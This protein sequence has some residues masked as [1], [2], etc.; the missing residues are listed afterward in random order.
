MNVKVAFIVRSTIESVPG[1]DTVQVFNTMKSLDALGISCELKLA[2]QQIHYSKYQ[3]L[4]FFNITRPSDITAHAFRSGLPF[5]ISP[6]FVD[7]SEYDK[8]HRKGLSG[9][10]FSHL[11]SHSIEYI[12]SI[13]RWVN[14]SDKLPD[15]AFIWQGHQKS[16]KQLLRKA[17]MVLPNSVSE[18]NRLKHAYRINFPFEVIPNGVN[19]SVFKEDYKFMRDP[20]LIICAARIEGIKNQLNLIKAL[21]DTNFRLIIIGDPAPNQLNYYKAC[22]KI[23]SDNIEFLPKIKHD[24]LKEFYSKASVHALPSWFET[25]GLSSLEAGAM[26]CKLVMSK[27]GDVYDYFADD[28]FYADPSSPAS[29]LQAIQIAA[30]RDHSVN[31]KKRIT[32]N[33]QWELAALRTRDAYL[34]VLRDHSSFYPDNT[35]IHTQGSN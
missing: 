2:E 31:L 20:N 7:Y 18:L 3:L 11:S 15:R 9:L 16:V 1:G 12:K 25:T 22:H 26:G 13:G 34:N 24:E 23:A 21:N 27:K 30:S 5:I 19:L 6:I 33:Y 17:S 10:L 28:V 8:I 35:H 14:G 29:I 32:E 4:H